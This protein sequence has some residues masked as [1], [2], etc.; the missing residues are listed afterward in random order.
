MQ[1]RKIGSL[2]IVL[3][4]ESL[5]FPLLIAMEVSVFQNPACPWLP[6]VYERHDG[7]LTRRY[8]EEKGPEFYAAALRY[9]HSQ[10]RLGKP[11]Q[12][13]LQLNKAWMADLGEA[14]EVLRM[15]PPPYRA[16]GWIMENA[17]ASG[18]G[19]LG[20][21]VRHFQHLASR[22]SGPRA[23]VRSARAWLCFHLAETLLPSENFPRDGVQLV[24]EGLWIP[25]W[26]CALTQVAQGGW[27]GE[28]EC[29]AGAFSAGST[30]QAWR[31]Q[32]RS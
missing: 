19:F 20:N 30:M 4:A 3:A 28:A 7:S 12:A 25:S 15:L 17:A 24:R 2:G 31:M 6:E 13:L 23:A 16:L 21:P 11:A 18:D 32:L 14:T 8:S 29:A 9:A 1:A 22:M 26:Q 10:W 5:H 27:P